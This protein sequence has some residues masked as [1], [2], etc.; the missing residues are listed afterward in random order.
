MAD[1]EVLIQIVQESDNIQNYA[2]AFAQVNSSS[3]LSTL[4]ALS[5]PLV[6]G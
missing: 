1:F 3:H 4:Q 5:R 2:N 6:G